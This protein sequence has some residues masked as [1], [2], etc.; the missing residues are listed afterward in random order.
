[1]EMCVTKWL[2]NNII[3]WRFRWTSTISNDLD[4][5]SSPYA[6]LNLKLI[7]IYSVSRC[8]TLLHHRRLFFLVYWSTP[9][10]RL[11]DI[12]LCNS[13]DLLGIEDSAHKFC[14]ALLFVS[15]L[16]PIP[17]TFDSI[18]P[19][20]LSEYRINSNKREC[21]LINNYLQQPIKYV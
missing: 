9:V 17:D 14:P 20:K 19:W 11:L 15:P 8:Y 12:L 10:E 16:R 5:V 4:K 6:E 7:L 3:N 13:F 2:K 18:L 21:K 1:M